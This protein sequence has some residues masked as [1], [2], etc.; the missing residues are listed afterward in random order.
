MGVTLIILVLLLAALA[1]T[2][3]GFAAWV[4]TSRHQQLDLDLKAVGRCL[5]FD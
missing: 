1:A 4:V 3:L 5:S 2:T